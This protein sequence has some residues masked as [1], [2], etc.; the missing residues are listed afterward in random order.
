MSK[1]VNFMLYRFYKK[2][3][4]LYRSITISGQLLTSQNE[5]IHLKNVTT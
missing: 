2:Q 4:K 3:K 1:M 5:S